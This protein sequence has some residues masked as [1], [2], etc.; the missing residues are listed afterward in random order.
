MGV[1]NCHVLSMSYGISGILTYVTPRQY[2]AIDFPNV[3][4]C[5]IQATREHV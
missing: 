5:H 4:S 2:Y 3:N 1:F